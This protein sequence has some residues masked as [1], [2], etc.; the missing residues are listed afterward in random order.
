MRGR[1]RETL[2]RLEPGLDGGL[3]SERLVAG[4]A[5]EPGRAQPEEAMWHPTLHPMGP[6]SVGGTAGVGC[7]A[8]WV[9]VKVR[10]LDGPDLGSRDWLWGCGTLPLREGARTGAGGGAL[11]TRSDVSKSKQLESLLETQNKSLL[12]TASTN[13]TAISHPT[14]RT[15]TSNNLTFGGCK[16]CAEGWEFHGGKCYFFSNEKMIWNKSRDQCVSKGGHLVIINSHEEQIFLFS[17]TKQLIYWIGMTDLVTEGEWLWVDNTPLNQTG[18]I[19][20]AQR[21]DGTKSEP[22]NWTQE[23]PLGEHCAALRSG[24]TDIPVW[25]DTSCR[26]WRLFVCETLGASSG[27]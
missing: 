5:T 15:L 20:W 14:Q 13:M 11:P 27:L 4:F 17:R 10:G 19:F 2:P 12:V 22:D 16:A 18:V 23:N 8:K 25:V 7:A 1:G 26:D 6:P 9:V 21:H 3:V 24:D